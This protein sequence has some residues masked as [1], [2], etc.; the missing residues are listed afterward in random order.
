MFRKRIYLDSLLRVDTSSFDHLDIECQIL[1]DKRSRHFSVVDFI[2]TTCHSSTTPHRNS[3]YATSV[4]RWGG[5]HNVWPPFITL[6]HTVARTRRQIS[7]TNR[8]SISKRVVISAR[9]YIYIYSPFLKSEGRER[10]VEGLQFP[11]D[12]GS[13]ITP[14]RRAS[15]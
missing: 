15:C 9:I 2:L 14:W 12:N 8:R 13:L 6:Y 3:H 1:C 7:G 10:E 11:M 4:R 5:L